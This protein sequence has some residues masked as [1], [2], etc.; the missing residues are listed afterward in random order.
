MHRLAFLWLA[1]ALTAQAPLQLDG[2]DRVLK[3][4][5]DQH[6]QRL[7]LFATDGETWE[8]AGGQMLHR[9]AVG[10][11]SPRRYGAMIHDPVRRHTLLFGG[12]TA[13][14]ALLADTWAW[15][16]FRWRP[17]PSAAAPSGRQLAGTAFDSGRGRVV[18]YGGLSTQ[19]TDTWEH[20]G[21]TWH[22]AASTGPTPGNPAMAYDEARA[23]TVLVIY[24]GFLGS[25]AETWEWN[26]SSWRPRAVGGPWP[27]QRQ[28]PG[29]VWDP[30]RRRTVM[31]GGNESPGEIW[32]WDG[33]SWRLA[34]TVAEPQRQSPIGWWD[35]ARG[36]IAM[37]GGSMDFPGGSGPARSDLWT[38]DG[39]NLGRVH[40][41]VRPSSRFSHGIAASQTTGTAL[42]FGGF[43]NVG[44]P[45]D[46]W[47]WNGA[48]WRQATPAVSPGPRTNP[49][50]AFD[51]GANRWLMFGGAA[52]ATALDEL[53]SFD[54]TNW[55]RLVTPTAPFPRASMGIAFDITR[56]TLVIFGGTGNGA[57][58]ND[59][60][61]W[62]G[63]AWRRVFTP[64]APS[65]RMDVPMDFDIARNRIVLF[66]GR[67][68]ATAQDQLA[69]TWEYDGTTWVRMQPTVSPPNLLMPSLVY[70]LTQG[71]CTMCGHRVVSQNQFDLERW[72]YDG[73]TWTRTHLD[74][75]SRLSSV[76]L[77]PSAISD[78]LAMYDG[79]GV[80]EWPSATPATN[81]P[82]GSGCG[83]PV[84]PLTTRARARLGDAQF[85]FETSAEPGDLVAFALALAPG[86][87][88]LGNGCTAW[89]QQLDAG[90]LQVT[91]TTGFVEQ[92]LPLP[93]STT[94]LGVSLFA[95]VFLFDPT[96]AMRTSA[97]LQT[98]L[99]N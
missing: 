97:G 7:V 84:P 67:I 44:N 5:W 65:A 22:L 68:G 62:N 34:A 59:T 2:P 66:G 98:R 12:A 80:T 6:R 61:E 77:L 37:F 25:P 28:Q 46:T 4:A 1:A 50:I 93:T 10:G 43:Q 21:T 64:N 87:Q 33:F 95:Q 48:A 73:T 57:M 85:G 75:N 86:N 70:E 51:L 63:T 81:A 94:W 47:L 78:R 19:T 60:W 58:G 23:L 79:L 35:P 11:P 92:R 41:D 29:L 83:T 36:A 31:F 91:P 9:P 56:N 99:G 30:A 39:Q 17:L 27:T 45:T 3:G 53:W 90:W 42:L 32:E 15:D 49:G 69:D 54:G 52:G 18:L 74:V 82:Y 20:D 96:A 88:P 55:Q 14:G 26:G 40:G 8:V 71:A 13:T 16:G 38:W 24:G 72:R 89:L 76:N